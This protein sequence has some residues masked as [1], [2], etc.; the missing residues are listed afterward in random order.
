MAGMV[1]F[2]VRDQAK[3]EAEAALTL[4][5]REKE[6]QIASMQRQIEDVRRRAEQG[7]QQ[8][9]GEVQELALEAM[10]RQK[11]PRD[12]F[13]PVP[14]GEFGGDLIQH[15]VG[16]VGQICGSILW[17]AKRTKNW[18]DGW[19]GKLRE[20]QRAAKTDVAVIVSHAL[21]KSLQTFD[22][23]RYLG[24]RPEMRHRC[25]HCEPRIAACRLHCR[26]RRRR[27]ADQDGDDLPIPDRPAVY[28]P[29]TSITA[30]YPLEQISLI[31]AARPVAGTTAAIASTA[32]AASMSF[33]WSPARHSCRIAAH[34]A[35]GA[36][37]ID[38]SGTPRQSPKIPQP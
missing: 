9:Q 11:F 31:S 10:L 4:R 15:V 6:E 36:I 22:H 12:A 29:S 17:E 27:S 33:I 16:P 23:R 3:Q 37:F 21:P 5:V 14:K 7:S 28:G 8:L 35:P 18:S 1:P 38:V 24:D 25:N 19:L 26:T 30:W 13:D 32:V 34:G 20:D 2:A